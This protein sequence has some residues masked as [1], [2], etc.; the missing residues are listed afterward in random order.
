MDNSTRKEADTLLQNISVVVISFVLFFLPIIFL[1]ATTD[2]FV[3]PKQLLV[4]SSSLLLLVIWG[5]RTV[6]N[7]KIVLISNPFTAPLFVFGAVVLASSILS[8]N[9]FDALLQSVPVICSLLLFFLIVNTVTDKKTFTM[10]VSA[11]SMGTVVAAAASF[12]AY[13]NIYVFPFA[14]VKSQAF[15]TFGSPIQEIVFLLP[16][17][18]LSVSVILKKIGFPKIKLE[19]AFKEDMSIVFHLAV[20]IVVI[21]SLALIAYQV[22]ALPQKPIILP[23]IYGFQTAFAAISQDAS[24]FIF[25]FLFGSGYGTFLTDFTRFKLPSFNMEPTIWNLSFSFSS[26]YFLELIATTGILGALSYLFILFK[27]FRA[28]HKEKNPVFM[29]VLLVFALSFLLPFSFTLI[30]LIFILLAFYVAYLGIQKDK[31]VY[32]YTLTLLSLRRSIIPF[33]GG[34]IAREEKQESTIISYVIFALSLAFVGFVG[35]YTTK[36]VMSDL[37]FAQSLKEAAKNNGQATYQL[38]QQAIQDFPYRSDYHRIFSQVNFALASALASN[39]PQGQQISQQTQQNILTLLQQAIAVAR[40]SVTLSPLTSA[41]WQ[42]LGQIYRNLINVGQNAESFSIA[43]LNQ[44]IALDPYNPQ[45]YVVLGGVYYQLNQFEQAQNQF[46]ISI[47]L[48]RDFANGYYNLGHALESKGDMQNALAAYQV[49]EQLAK[50]NPD[51]ISK[52]KSEID[53]LKAKIG[54]VT[55]KPQTNIAP[56]TNQPPI[57]VNQPEVTFP[58]QKPPVKISPPPLGPEKPSVTP[59]PSGQPSVTPS[60]TKAQ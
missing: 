30:T 34:E 53:A 60:P 45:L 41:N 42:N 56:T 24:R 12:L 55:T 19:N 32:D 27:V 43:S 2:F 28:R 22:I 46:Q 3:F 33:E 26:S 58:P 17:L 13:F 10:V 38:Q 6:I 1:T 9:R 49:V 16:V 7:K 44:A 18:L 47:N 36:L 21:A 25:S 59:S 48:K 50:D 35:F 40:N 51:S 54:D 39:V 20:S 37:K 8:L 23:Y 31:K 29:A 57:N 4:I 15:N 11:L 14:E 5:V 52:I